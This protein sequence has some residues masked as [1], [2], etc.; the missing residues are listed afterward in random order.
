MAG[1]DRI[2]SFDEAISRLEAVVQEL[3]GGGLPLEKALDLFA[4]GIE[5]SRICSRNLRAAEQR[6]AILTRDD[7]GALSLKDIDSLP[8]AL[9]GNGCGL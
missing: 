2:L 5:L 4:E 9:E 8:A 6:I 3:E 7:G 1:E